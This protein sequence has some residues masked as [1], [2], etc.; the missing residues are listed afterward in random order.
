M[1]TNPFF[2]LDDYRQDTFSAV[3][4]NSSR[5]STVKITSKRDTTFF[6]YLI[7]AGIIIGGLFALEKKFNVFQ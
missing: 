7:V 4:K 6:D 3:P 1:N 2:N 5:G